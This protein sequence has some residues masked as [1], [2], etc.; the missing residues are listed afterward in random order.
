MIIFKKI[1]KCF[2]LDFY[3]TLEKQIE[4]FGRPTS[5]LNV[6]NEIEKLF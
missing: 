1:N 5:K 2:F 3:F 4:F 6:G